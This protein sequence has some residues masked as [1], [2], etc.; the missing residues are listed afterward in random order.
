[1]D[2]EVGET[3]R[4]GSMVDTR[5]SCSCVQFAG[6]QSASFC[7]VCGHPRAQH[8]GQAGASQQAADVVS[9]PQREYGIRVSLPG[10]DVA[11][12]SPPQVEYG[13]RVSLDAEA[14]SAA[15]PAQVDPP[16]R[17]I[18]PWH[19]IAMA[20]G[21]LLIAIA[22]GIAILNGGSGAARAPAARSAAITSHPPPVFAPSIGIT[23]KV[24][25]KP[26]LSVTPA[27]NGG[28]W[29]QTERGNLTRLA[30]D[31]GD[32]AYGFRTRMPAL[33]LAVSG[34]SLEVLTQV[35]VVVRDRGTGRP[36]RAL[37]LPAPPVCCGLTAAGGVQWEWLASGLARIDLA[38]GAITVQPSPV[39]SGMAGD[40]ARLWLLGDGSLTPVDTASGQL[41]AAVA[42]GD[43]DLRA[44]ALGADAM[45]G[46]GKRGSQPV[47]VRFD[48]DSGARQLVIA[49]PAVASAVTVS[50]GAVWLA[51]P[52]IGLKELDPSTNSLT[53][54]PIAVVHPRWLLPATNDQ[55]WVIGRAAGFSTFTRLDLHPSR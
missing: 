28:L 40:Q 19:L 37:A 45:W 18:R 47:V 53:G 49:L 6:D 26:G 15:A 31:T 52:T 23:A 43:V 16:R 35:A 20:A 13:L 54:D 5:C 39:V 2:S 48:P 38:S 4:S 17:R 55:L 32:V 21:A 46:I 50:D 30:A 9:A 27:L 10:S 14:A 7:A 33:G 1:M 44:I 41:S 11:P 12:V 36:Q 34:R 8:G 42:V 3:V 22:G 51:M 29:Y 24:K 25:S